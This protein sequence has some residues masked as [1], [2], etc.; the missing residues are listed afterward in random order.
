MSTLNCNG[1]PSKLS[2]EQLGRPVLWWKDKKQRKQ[3]EAREVCL[4]LRRVRTVEQVEAVQAPSLG[5]FTTCLEKAPGSLAWS[6]GWPW[7]GQ[8]VGPETWSPFPPDWLFDP[9]IRSLLIETIRLKKKHLRSNLL[10][11]FGCSFPSFNSFPSPV[12]ELP[13]KTNPQHDYICI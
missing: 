7:F 3:V 2:G 12:H 8:E 9:I 11:M 5:G 1:L 4:T 13:Y 10:T 6:Q